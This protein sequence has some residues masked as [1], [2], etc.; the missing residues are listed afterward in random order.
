M[1]VSPALRR[2]RQRDCHKLK[3]SHGYIESDTSERTIN[4]RNKTTR[5]KEKVNHNRAQDESTRLLNPLPGLHLQSTC[6]QPR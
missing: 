2:L 5:L 4:N 6:S 1:P 3:D